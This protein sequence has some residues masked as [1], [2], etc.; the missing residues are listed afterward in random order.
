MIPEIDLFK[1]RVRQNQSTIAQHVTVG[2]YRTVHPPLQSG[3]QTDRV[4]AKEFDG[5]WSKS[6]IAGLQFRLALR[7][8]LSE[9]LDRFSHVNG[10]RTTGASRVTES[11][12]EY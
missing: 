10:H 1:I 2:E 9:Q 7:N 4:T 8:Y 5:S 3:R 6:K 12:P 11:T